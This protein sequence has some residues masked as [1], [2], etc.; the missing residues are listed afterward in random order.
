MGTQI[1]LFTD[2]ETRKKTSKL[3]KVIDDINRR[4]GKG[5]ITSAAEAEMQK[6]HDHAAPISNDPFH[7]EDGL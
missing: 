7:P 4:Y 6:E 2:E 1:S 3:D 5:V